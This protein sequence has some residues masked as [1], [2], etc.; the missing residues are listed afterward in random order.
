MCRL[1]GFHSAVRSR[2]HHSLVAAENALV[3][4]SMD[5]PDGW[6]VAYYQGHFPH[7]IRSDKQALED[8]LFRDLSGV[9]STHTLVAHIR[10]ATVGDVGILNCHPF[11]HGPWTFAHNGEIAGFSRSPEIRQAMKNAVDERF[12]GHLFGATDTELLFHLFLSRLARK[13]ED[14]FH[15][16]VSLT[17]VPNSLRETITET[18][19]IA[20]ETTSEE[21]KL[22]FLLS[23]GHIILGYRHRKDLFYSTYKS[24]CPERD[25]CASFEESRCEREV[26]DGLVKHLIITS[27][28]IST[29]PNA[30]I[31]VPDGQFVAVGHGMNFRRGLLF[32]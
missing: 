16:G 17:S 27:E 26:G 19:K 31:S 20:D 29:G 12:R 4:Q 10:Q 28:H 21:S 7:V 8:G 23:N 2:V 5:H 14:I 1:Y 15:E 9:V 18:Q 11:Q 32:K 6:G 25:T 22:T 30:W 13:V 3:Q 24:L